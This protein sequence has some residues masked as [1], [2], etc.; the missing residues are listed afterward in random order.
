MNEIFPVINIKGDAEEIGFQIGSKISDRIRKALD[1]YKILWQKD[2]EIILKE[3]QHFKKHINDFDSNYGAEIEG[4]ARG[5]NIDADWIYALNARSEILTNI[6]E[7]INEC[8]AISCKHLGISGQNWDWSQEL[9]PLSVILR[10][11]NTSRNNII[12][13]MTEP[14]IIGKIGLNNAG[15]GVCLNF[16]H[17]GSKELRGVPIHIILRA[18]L[19]CPSLES[20]LDKIKHALLGK[21]ANILITDAKGNN[22]D[23]EFHNTRVLYP[24]ISINPYIHTNHYLKEEIII[25]KKDLSSSFAR[26]EKATELALKNEIKTIQDIKNILLNTDNSELPIC[27]KYVPDPLIRNVGTIASII[28]D[29]RNLQMHITKGNPIENPFETINVLN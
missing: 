19:D 9:E 13:M 14:G 18:V 17:G 15:V 28:M 11:E 3:V 6:A 4:I 20:S 24:D 12:L 8:T 26:H 1:F 21:E 7:T 5:A 16:M 10:I 2:E 27:R 29:H 25:D 23:I 22:I